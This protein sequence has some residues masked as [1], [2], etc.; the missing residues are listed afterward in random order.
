MTSSPIS[1]DF[2]WNE[3]LSVVHDYVLCWH[4]AHHLGVTVWWWRHITTDQY[5][6]RGRLFHLQVLYKYKGG[7]PQKESQAIGLE[8]KGRAQGGFPEGVDIWTF[9]FMSCWFVSFCFFELEK[10]GV[11]P[12]SGATS[13]RPRLLL[14]TFGCCSWCQKQVGCLGVELGYSLLCSSWAL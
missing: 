7:G 10:D 4:S 9:C 5:N 12:H 2:M 8:E 3:T 6:T 1:W 13:N 11:P 14:S